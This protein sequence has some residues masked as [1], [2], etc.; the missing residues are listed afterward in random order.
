MVNADL[1]GGSKSAKRLE[2]LVAQ[3]RRN[4]PAAPQA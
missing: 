3:V 4:F 2:I 1:S